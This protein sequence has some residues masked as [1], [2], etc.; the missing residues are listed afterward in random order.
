MKQF[1]YFLLLT[2]FLGTYN[3]R[4]QSDILPI[5]ESKKGASIKVK[6]DTIIQLGNTLYLSYSYEYTNPKDE[7]AKYNF[8]YEENNDAYK[9]ISG[10]QHSSSHNITNING[11]RK[12][13]HKNTYSF[14]LSF[15]KEG[16]YKM[17]TLRVET[18]SNK[19]I[20][21]KPFT[22]RATKENIPVKKEKK[23][24]PTSK[25][26][27]NKSNILV[28]EAIVSNNCITLGDSIECE[29]RLY[30]KNNVLS[31]TS[32][33]KISI[34][35]T[36]WKEHILPKER[37][38]KEVIYKGDSVSSY[39]LKRFTITP[40]QAGEIILEPIETLISIKEKDNTF[41]F[42][43]STF[44]FFNAFDFKPFTRDTIL[45]TK[46]IKIKVKD[47]DI[48]AETFVFDNSTI[49]NTGIIVDRS[50]SLMLQ[51]KIDSPSYSEL[52]NHFL[53]ALLNKKDS[54]EYSLTLFAGKAHYPKTTNTKEILELQPS[55]ENDGSAVYNAILAASLRDGALTT[56]PVKKTAKLPYS[57]LL[58]TDGSD[59]SSC[60]SEKTLTNLLLKHNI[61]VDVVVF[62]SK[63][64]KAYCHYNDSLIKIDYEQDF[65]D[66]ERIA[67]NTNGEFIVIENK[68][69]IPDA[70][71]KIRK[72]IAKRETTIQQPED[73]F[74]PNEAI[75]Q[76]L[77]KRI[78]TQAESNF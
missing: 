51:S 16:R 55:E 21:S 41:S 30:Y 35:P 73:S 9:V 10:P 57:I 72:K 58:L 1:I 6:A 43:D 22:I 65:T 40:M 3:L 25:Q 47:K 34:S 67:K 23:H 71:Q 77:Y 50:S 59:N 48:P 60:L 63:E 31:S 68:D 26:T 28:A 2:T 66:V 11:I 75:L 45:K 12:E 15:E 37:I 56:E 70:V 33:R 32:T 62:A 18:V 8:D 64:G 24:R 42:I 78:I 49:H 14:L 5:N 13:T 17:P 29:V 36:Y 44:S 39:L 74:K 46:R 69:Q 19:E 54:E 52:L 61:R 76:A 27:D 53:K 38:S 7:I 4:A 20:I